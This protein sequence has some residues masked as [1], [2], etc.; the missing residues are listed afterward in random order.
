LRLRQLE[1]W[2]LLVGVVIVLAFTAAAALL[3]GGGILGGFD[4]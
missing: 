2:V 4:G 1:R 3:I